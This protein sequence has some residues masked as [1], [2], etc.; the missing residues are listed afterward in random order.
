M[1]SYATDSGERRYVPG[2]LGVLSIVAAL[3]LHKLLSFLSIEWP[4]FAVPWWFDAPSVMGFYAIFYS[5]FE[6]RAWKWN[7]LRRI[8]IVGLP[9]LNGTWRGHLRSIHDNYKTHSS[10]A[11]HLLLSSS[12]ISMKPP[13]SFYDMTLALPL[14]PCP[15]L[16]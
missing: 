16:S 12:R 5:V 9:D 11:W 2:L 15:H 3:L 7:L 14:R 8:G 4:W 10:A 1:H 6:K 13:I